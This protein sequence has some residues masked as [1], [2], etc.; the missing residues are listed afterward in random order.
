MDGGVPDEYDEA[1]T[2]FERKYILSNTRPGEPE[3]HSND[4]IHQGS[5]G[6]QWR[7]PHGQ[8]GVLPCGPASA[9]EGAPNDGKIPA[10]RNS[11]TK[12]VVDVLL[13]LFVTWMKT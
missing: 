13:K 2:V 6:D 12:T 1:A 7:D 10:M 4:S 3:V 5:G 11:H 8:C 9:E